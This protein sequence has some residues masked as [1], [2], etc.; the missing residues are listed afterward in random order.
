M[1]SKNMFDSQW[2]DNDNNFIP[3]ST[4]MRPQSFDEFVGQ[5]HIIGKDKV[6]RRTI[7]KGEVP[8]IIFW[9][10]P[11]S[12]K[13]TLAHLIARHTQSHFVSISAITS[14]VPEVKKL[15][16][17]AQVIR[18]EQNYKSILFIDEIH[19]FN[20][21]QQHVILPYIEDGTITL[22]GATTE[23]PSFEIIT[24][25]LPRTR[26]FT[27]KSLTVQD[28]RNLVSNALN[29]HVQGLRQLNVQIEE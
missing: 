21:A 20:K 28:L 15:I 19:R 11:G 6:L 18:K 22:I 16:A 24:P 12:G 17:H 4:R 29:N 26:V 14:G 10:P 9:G 27:L 1:Q 2:K 7:E 5:Q 8:S 25:L 3:L 23:N 13:T